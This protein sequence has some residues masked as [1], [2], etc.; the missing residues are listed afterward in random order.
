M[1]G[2]IIELK[3]D[4]R[5]GICCEGGGAA[6]SYQAGMLIALQELF[7]DRKIK[8]IS[9]SSVGGLNAL[10]AVQQDFDQLENMWRGLTRRQ[11]F[12]YWGLL[13]PKSGGLYDT[14]PLKKLLEKNVNI[15]EIMK[16]PIRLFLQA[17]DRDRGVPIIAQNS[18]PELILMALASASILIA[19]PQVF[20]PSRGLWAVDGG[21]YD[22]SPLS[23]LVEQVDTR[24]HASCDLIFILHCSPEQDPE[25]KEGVRHRL[26]MVGHTVRL[27]YRCGQKS[28][29][30]NLKFHNFLIRVGAIE[31]REIFVE[32]LYPEED[33][34]GTFD[35]D[36]K[37]INLALDHGFS[38][39]ENMRNEIHAAVKSVYGEE[40]DG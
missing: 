16:S 13:K 28:D 5:I 27:L 11:V 37:K 40:Y 10:S 24:T 8:A 36:N 15:R 29:E 39:V 26:G 9:G 19:F 32:H 6:G 4:R 30:R 12:S 20:V 1:I 22:N 17:T 18:D 21:V 25:Q 35:F 33:E 2:E 7:K 14:K 3:E 31:G 34:V 38:V 23:W